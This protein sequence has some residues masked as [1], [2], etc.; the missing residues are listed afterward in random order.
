MP[1]ITGRTHR[2]CKLNNGNIYS[3]ATLEDRL[4][5]CDIIT[6]VQFLINGDQLEKIL[7]DIQ[8]N[9]QEDVS[10]YLIDNNI[11]DLQSYIE[12]CCSS[13]FHRAGDQRKLL[14]VVVK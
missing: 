1:L 7:V 13:K 2:I 14:R 12:I 3:T 8:D 10:K 6:D 4:L 11:N 9:K 5:E